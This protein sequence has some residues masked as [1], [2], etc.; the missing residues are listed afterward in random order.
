MIGIS[1]LSAMLAKDAGNFCRKYAPN[2]VIKNGEFHL[3]SVAGEK[4]ESLKV[5]V[6]GDRAGVWADFATGESGDLIDLLSALHG[7]PIAEAMREAK[8]FLGVA[9][10]PLRRKKT[11]DKPVK[12]RCKAATEDQPAVKYLTS[13]GISL[14][15]AKDWKLGIE[16]DA[17]IFPFIRD[18]ELVMCKRLK[19][20]REKGK[21]D[22]R[23]TSKNQEHTLFGWHM[24]GNAR[25]V[26]I[27]EGEIDAL[28]WHQ[29]GFA[30]LS[31]PFGC[32]QGG[33]LE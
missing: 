6:K 29:S 15:T 27:C 32:G 23:P 30:A 13:R 10:E 18:G 31:V 28:S 14:N 9:D 21:K 8:S 3:G 17:V 26:V 22:I 2:G 5:S 20:E 33:K 4:G 16:L 12:P 24:I 11:Y 19:I 25:Q 7:I 1:E